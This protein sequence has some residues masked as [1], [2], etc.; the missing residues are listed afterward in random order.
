[1][2][3]TREREREMVEG[4]V[5][6]LECLLLRNISRFFSIQ[7]FP[8]LVKGFLY[9]WKKSWKGR[10]DFKPWNVFVGWSTS[11]FFFLLSFSKLSFLVKIFRIYARRG[12]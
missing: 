12:I 9:L 11:R 10:I 1:M 5:F 7:S 8:S 3:N 2:R 6:N 4:L